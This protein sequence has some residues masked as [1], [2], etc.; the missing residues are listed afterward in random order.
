MSSTTEHFCVRCKK[1][2]PIESYALKKDGAP[3]KQCT[4]CRERR[5]EWKKKDAKKKA[6]KRVALPLGIQN[7][8]ACY[9]DKSLEQ[10]SVKKNGTPMRYCV[11]CVER[12]NGN[13]CKH[14]KRKSRCKICDGK[15][16]CKEH[17]RLKDKCVECKGSGICVHNK[18]RNRCKDCGGS[19]V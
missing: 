10:F 2:K 15:D 7:C 1:T 11:E 4:E 19:A 16:Y 12:I 3:Y 14:G 13:K 8:G 6:E 17:G 18:R 9:K 5:D